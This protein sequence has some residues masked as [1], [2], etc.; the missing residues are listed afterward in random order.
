MMDDSE[1]FLLEIQD[2]FLDET[3]GFLEQTENNFLEFEATPSDHSILENILR[4]AH[5][6]KGSAAAVGFDGFSQFAH[7][8]ENLLVKI[9]QGGVEPVPEIIDILLVSNDMLKTYVDALREDKAA[10]VDTSTVVDRINS[11]IDAGDSAS[12]KDV[13]VEEEAVE[14]EVVEFA[15]IEQEEIVEVAASSAAE[16]AIS[17]AAA[18]SLAEMGIDLAEVGVSGPKISSAAAESLAEMGIDLAEA[19]I[20]ET[21]SSVAEEPVAK[22]D[23]KIDYDSLEDILLEETLSDVN[24]QTPLSIDTDSIVDEV[25]GDTEIEEQIEEVLDDEEAAAR[26]N[27]QKPVQKPKLKVVKDIPEAKSA[28]PVANIPTTAAKAAK[29]TEEFIRLPL[30]KIEDLLNDLSEQVILQST[31]DL[32]RQDIVGNV[33]EVNRTVLQ[34]GKITNELQQTAISLRMLSLKGVFSKMQRTIRDTAKI[35]N[36][37]IRFVTDGDDT[38][39]DK[40]II[41]ELSSPLTHLIRNSV[42]HGVETPDER[43]AAG[44][45]RMG[46]VTMTAS[47]SGRYFYLKISDDGK[48]LDRDLI[49][50][51][52]IEKG[53]VSADDELS[54]QQILQLIFMNSFSTKDE[55]TDISGRGVGMDAIKGAIEKLRGSIELE[56]EVGKGTTVTI[57]LPPTLAIFN[58]IVIESSGQKFIFPSSDVLEIYHVNL[59]DTR[60]MSPGN[61]IIRIKDKVYPVID[62]NK[63][64]NLPKSESDRPN[65]VLITVACNNKAYGVLVDDVLLQQRIVFKNL[66]RE[67]EGLPGVAGGTI[68]ADGRVAM[69]V[70]VSDLVELYEK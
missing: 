56:S 8:F 33:D 36:K 20:T 68:L 69:I 11:A 15:S 27:S 5:N 53:I 58:G 37:E 25:T 29:K 42:D 7:T 51:K 34:L 1:D 22:Q 40:T 64:F 61:P 60:E 57:K 28:T 30:R 35:L 32:L 45:P 24:E 65:N 18:E 47:Y 23:T 63:I 38:E 66:G 44:K 43:E 55:A 46:T 41:D 70:E 19:G 14:E 9:K 6:I 17:A 12:A 31:L 2:E 13:P 62:L 16:P 59:E 67:L 10:N 4:L 39:L 50:Q 54:E 26:Q 52:A 48:G 49:R 21:A 3:V